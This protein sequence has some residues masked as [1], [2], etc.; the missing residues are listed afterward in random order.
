MTTLNSPDTVI[1]VVQIDK[2]KLTPDQ[3]AQLEPRVIRPEV[4]KHLPPLSS[5]AR[6]FEDEPVIMSKDDIRHKPT[7]PFVPFAMG[8]RIGDDDVFWTPSKKD[9]TVKIDVSQAEVVEK[10]VPPPPPKFNEAPTARMVAYDDSDPFA[11]R[12][13]RLRNTED[14]LNDGVRH[15]DTPVYLLEYAVVVF[16]PDF[17][18]LWV[19]DNTDLTVG[20]WKKIPCLGQG[21]PI[22]TMLLP[23]PKDSTFVAIVNPEYFVLE[24][25]PDEP[26][27]RWVRC[28]IRGTWDKFTVTWMQLIDS[29]SFYIRSDTQHALVKPMIKVDPTKTR[30]RVIHTIA[31]KIISPHEELCASERLRSTPVAE[32]L[33]AVAMMP[34][35]ALQYCT[36]Y[37][38]V[39]VYAPKARNFLPTKR[40]DVETPLKVVMPEKGLYF[41]SPHKVHRAY[42][43][44]HR[45]RFPV[46]NQSGFPE[47]E[48]EDVTKDGEVT[49]NIRKDDVVA[50]SPMHDDCVLV[51][52]RDLENY[53]VVELDRFAKVKKYIA[54]PKQ[55]GDSG[56]SGLYAAPPD[57][58]VDATK[59][60]R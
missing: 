38:W 44:S 21:P 30:T 7:P 37:V 41:F 58:E 59:L 32:E 46:F 14:V 20:N 47:V 18:V 2:L 9:N 3:K 10:Q 19:L 36:G 15:R 33:E 54:L 28:R 22:G 1:P 50:L 51:L 8:R 35:V 48:V 12:M 31:S 29:D 45:I 27:A 25:I 23:N 4:K 5:Y 56:S 24:L 57:D 16:T 43:A 40:I 60:L 55:K 17:S 6:M 42:Q 13:R 52:H 11:S 39:Y 34:G 26:E 49:L 53:V